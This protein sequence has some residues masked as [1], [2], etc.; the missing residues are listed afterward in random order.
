M[1]KPHVDTL[2]SEDQLGSLVISLPTNHE[3]G[4]LVVRN[5]GNEVLFD[6]SKS[7]NRKDPLLCIKCAAFYS[8]CEHEVLEVT[9]GHRITQTYNLFVTRGLGYLGVASALD[10]TT[11]PLY[12]TLR[13]ALKKSSFFNKGHVIAVWM[14]NT[15]GL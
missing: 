12:K 15:L 14:S 1:L 11:L 13:T 6:W 2:R 8:D 4:Q 7:A 3:E 9:S 10:A 5:A